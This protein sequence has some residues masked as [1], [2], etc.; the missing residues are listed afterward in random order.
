MNQ[1]RITNPTPWFYRLTNN[2][3]FFLSTWVLGFAG[4][5]WALSL[6]LQDSLGVTPSCCSWLSL[7]LWSPAAGGRGV[8]PGCCGWQ[9]LG[10]GAE[11]NCS[12]VT[13]AAPPCSPSFWHCCWRAFSRCD[14]FR[15]LVTAWGRG[16]CC[17]CCGSEGSYKSV[18]GETGLK[19]NLSIKD[20]LWQ[21]CAG[22]AKIKI[23]KTQARV[24]REGNVGETSG[25]WKCFVSLR[26]R[27][28]QGYQY[29]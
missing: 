16:C 25:A 22:Q 18:S 14:C 27:N 26:I 11:S 7:C 3:T 1:Y 21:S 20:R 8:G 15:V 12:G 6:P 9:G 19:K 24:S 2:S 4:R 28:F 23:R 13:G 17:C 10:C 29:P 5:G